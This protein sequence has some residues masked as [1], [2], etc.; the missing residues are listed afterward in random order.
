MVSARTLVEQLEEASRED[1]VRMNMHDLVMPLKLS[2][3]HYRQDTTDP[4]LMLFK[5]LEAK[6]AARS[7]LV[8][9]NIFVNPN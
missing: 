5:E 6:E 7:L 8:L 9:P 2:R 4:G 3:R 1:F